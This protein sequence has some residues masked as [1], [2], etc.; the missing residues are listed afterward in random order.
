[1]SSTP[2]DSK[3]ISSSSL[4]RIIG[5]V[6]DKHVN[7]SWHSM[8]LHIKRLL[9]VREYLDVIAE[10]IGMCTNSNGEFAYPLLEFAFKCCIIRA[11]AYVELPDN[12]DDL[13]SV[14]YESG[15]YDIVYST[16]NQSQINDIKHCVLRFAEGGGD[17]YGGTK[18]D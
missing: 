5:N 1:M 13:Y 3:P 4:K 11:Y 15:I 2:I 14:V 6:Y 18:S 7:A 8:N 12:L 9:T 16:A 17:I 10:V